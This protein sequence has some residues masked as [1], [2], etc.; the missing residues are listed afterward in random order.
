MYSKHFTAKPLQFCFK[1]KF[2][3]KFNFNNSYVFFCVNA[4]R[5]NLIKHKYIQNKDF[6]LF[7]LTRRF[8]FCFFFF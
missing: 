3:F 7:L 4:L 2:N 6:K 5:K 8:F 1:F